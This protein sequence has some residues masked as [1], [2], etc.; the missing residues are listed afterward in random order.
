MGSGGCSG[1]ESDPCASS[2]ARAGNVELMQEPV[3]CAVTVATRSREALGNH[4]VGRAGP[5]RGPGPHVDG[6]SQRLEPRVNGMIDGQ[7]RRVAGVEPRWGVVC[8]RV[9]PGL[10]PLA[11]AVQQRRCPDPMISAADSSAKLSRRSRS[12]CAR[13]R[14]RL[15]AWSSKVGWLRLATAATAYDSGPSARSIGP[16]NPRAPVAARS[17]SLTAE[18]GSARTPGARPA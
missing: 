5:A 8:G 3:R 17:A 12:G 16:P 15:I 4:G 18:A 7:V 14:W 6:R 13:R 2:R 1:L 11:A 9:L 10:C